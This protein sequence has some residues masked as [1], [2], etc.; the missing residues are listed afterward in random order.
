M[1]VGLVSSFMKTEGDGFD[2]M[3]AVLRSPW[4]WWSLGGAAVAVGVFLFFTRSMMAG[5]TVFPL[6]VVLIEGG[7]RNRWWRLLVCA[8]GIAL[9][10]WGC[11][12]PDSLSGPF[13]K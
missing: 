2:R 6:G 8:V 9:L 5:L 3:M 11:F 12:R 10:A 7:V 1:I 4:L 13:L